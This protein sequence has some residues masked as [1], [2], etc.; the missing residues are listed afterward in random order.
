LFLSNT[1]PRAIG[2]EASAGCVTFAPGPRG[3]RLLG[4]LLEVRRDRINFV[5]RAAKQYGDFVGFRM[6]R[7]RLYLLSHPEHARQV[8]CDNPSNYRKGIGQV[9]AGPL[10]GQGLLT[11]EG[12]LW[13]SQRQLLQAA[14]HGE[15]LSRFTGEMVSATGRMLARWERAASGAERTLDVAEEMVHLALEILGATLFRFDFSR[16]AAAL[17]ADLNILTGW[18]MASMMSPLGMP[19]SLP[20]PRNLRARW[21]LSRLDSVARAMI[22]TRLQEGPDGSPD[23]LS[24]LLWQSP[25]AT[26]P[27]G[28]GYKQVRDEVMTF[29]LAGHETTAATLTWTL[30]L[31]ARHPWVEERLRDE[32][33]SV[34]GSRAPSQADLP[35]LVYTRMVIEESLRLYP[36]IW[37]IPRR[38]VHPDRIGCYEVAASSDILLCVYSLH[39][40]ADFWPD[41]ERFDPERFSAERTAA[42]PSYSYLPFGA[43][44]RSCLGGRFGMMEAVLVLAMIAQK[45]RLSLAP[46]QSVRP[47]ASLSLRPHGGLPMRIHAR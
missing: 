42:R 26:R 34:L 14:F 28:D 25:G 32:L 21:A 4:S 24:L 13:A 12:D 17:A 18:A 43:G 10:L 3:R 23:L 6:G 46:G 30:Y 20:T 2:S 31:L 8:L 1:E 7:R 16:I 15:Q 9:E 44:P 27:P 29:V 11:S 5:T 36:P 41:P 39:R 40:H 38:A 19:L 35:Q 47:E 45:Y 37:L 22:Q 33:S